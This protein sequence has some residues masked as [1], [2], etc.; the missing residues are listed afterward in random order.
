MV[1]K[2]IGT[3]VP[4]LNLKPNHSCT[5]PQTHANFLCSLQPTKHWHDVRSTFS[6]TWSDEQHRVKIAPFSRPRLVFEARRCDTRQRQRSCKSTQAK[7]GRANVEPHEHELGPTNVQGSG[8]YSP[9]S[10]WLETPRA[11]PLQRR[12]PTARVSRGKK[13]QKCL[14]SSAEQRQR[15]KALIITILC[16]VQ[17]L[18]QVWRLSIHAAKPRCQDDGT[19]MSTLP[20]TPSK[21]NI[22]ILL[23]IF[24]TL[25]SKA[26]V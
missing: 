12:A 20:V 3:P 11:L 14:R 24:L 1:D 22:V 23:T 5:P 7:R 21:T 4:P 19:V 8:R 6:W 13:P 2:I 16:P 26:T 18:L 15:S 10:T 25:L 9:R 17:T